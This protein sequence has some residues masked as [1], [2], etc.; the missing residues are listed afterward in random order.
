MVKGASFPN[1]K[2]LKFALFE[3]II[4]EWPL[5][6]VVVVVAGGMCSAQTQHVKDGK[7]YFL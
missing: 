1:V 6:V 5:S 4:L 7:F 2:D 3:S